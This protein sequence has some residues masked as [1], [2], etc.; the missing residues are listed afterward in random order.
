[1]VRIQCSID[2][3][4]SDKADDH[5]QEDQSAGSDDHLSDGGDSIDS[6]EVVDESDS[7]KDE[8]ETRNTIADVLSEWYQELSAGFLRN[9]RIKVQLWF[10]VIRNDSH[11]ISGKVLFQ[12]YQK[13]ASKIET[14]YR[15]Y[16]VIVALLL[17]R[18]KEI[19]SLLRVYRHQP[20]ETSRKV[21]RYSKTS[22]CVNIMCV[23]FKTLGYEFAIWDIRSGNLE[24]G[25]RIL[26]GV[27]D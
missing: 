2:G 18:F 5:N 20:P 4:S 27:P 21:N 14:D 23:N 15:F 24:N 19:I 22:G 16:F 10:L 7:S 11:A 8:V 12:S 3:G 9:K 6:C 25:D 1:M 26:V 13:L 17:L